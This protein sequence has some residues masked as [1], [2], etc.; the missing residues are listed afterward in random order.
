MMWFSSLKLNCLYIVSFKTLLTV[1]LLLTHQPCDLPNTFYII[2]YCQNEM[3]MSNV[4]TGNTMT[5]QLIQIK[6]LNRF[7]LLLLV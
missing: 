2:K 4:E 3:D 5:A 1:T 6:V 7:C